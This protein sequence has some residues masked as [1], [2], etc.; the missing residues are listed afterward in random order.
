M[1]GGIEVYPGP[2]R[3]S[4]RS[5]SFSICHWNLNSLIAHSFAK[6]SLL[7]A[8]LSVSLISYVYQ[9]LFLTVKF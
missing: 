1:S 2:E 8:Y 7:T 4:C 6:V 9:K 5:Q 3:N